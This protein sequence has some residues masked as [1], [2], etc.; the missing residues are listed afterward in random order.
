MGEILDFFKKNDSKGE[1]V[2][3]R[4]EIVELARQHAIPALSLDPSQ[5]SGTSFIGGPP[6]LPVN[7]DWPRRGERLLTFIACIDLDEVRQTKTIPWLPDRGRLLFFYDTE[8]QP[9]GFDPK[10][11]DGWK[12]LLVEDGAATEKAEGPSLNR[13]G[14][15]FRRFDSL[16]DIQRFDD[17]GLVIS[18]QEE[19]DW[20]DGDMQIGHAPFQIGGY[21]NPVQN[22]TMELECQLVSNG[23][24]C[25][26][27]TGYKDPRA[28]ELAE[29]ADEWRL[30]LQLDSEDDLGEMWGDCGLIYFWIRETDARAA[31]FDKAWLVLQ[32]S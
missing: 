20:F 30:L 32:C 18:E 23:L 26:D 9:W 1:A 7:A 16:P 28:A 10:D 31:N 29:C 5:E 27:S 19:D 14:L 2:R 11:A 17:L 6:P 3:S 15:N 21:P 13:I 24:Y 8:E 4:A 25:G 12:V 22:D